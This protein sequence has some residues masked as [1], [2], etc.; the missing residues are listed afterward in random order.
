M[1]II[2]YNEYVN[3][4]LL[5]LNERCNE[6]YEAMMDRKDD[7]VLRISQSILEIIELIKEYH[8]D[9]KLLP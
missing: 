2:E 1:G 3:R 9:E 4:N 5:E 8:T 6:L 7:E